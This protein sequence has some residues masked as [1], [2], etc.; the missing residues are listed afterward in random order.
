MGKTNKYPDID[1][2][3]LA[4]ALFVIA[5][6]TSP[7]ATYSPYADFLVTRVAGR[8]AVP[9]FLM[10]SGF[11]LYGSQGWN[12]EK[13]ITFVRKT[14]ILYGISILI[15]LPVNWYTGYWRDK[16]LVL[17]VFRDIM[18]DGTMYHLWYLP[19]AI[20]GSIISFACYKLLGMRKAL[21]VTAILYLIGVMGDSYYGIVSEV[22][23]IGTFYRELFKVM[24]NTRNGIFFAPL[25]F[26]LGGFFKEHR[27]LKLKYSKWMFWCLFLI[28]AAEA[29]W[30]KRAGVM[31]HDSMY[32]LLPAV[33][34]FLFMILLHKRGREYKSFRVISMAVYIIHP[35][36]I[37][38]V[39]GVSKVL[40]IQ[41]YTVN[42]SIVHFLLISAGSFLLGG[43]YYLADSK[44]RRE[45]K[46]A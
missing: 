20:I 19:A 6:H 25:F 12:R 15:Y 17:K 24:D 38:G 4:A 32:L 23:V 30:L 43:I 45:R 46:R 42:N 9:F 39:R 3:R 14:A 18:M 21:I 28:M 41:S 2:F 44:F 5:I 40:R 10:V 35:W 1:R 7:L 8:V 36:V 16:N 34:F 22:P 29:I 11:F 31:R 33:M 13:L 27:S 37:I 26:L